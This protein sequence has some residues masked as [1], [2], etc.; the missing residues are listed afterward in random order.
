MARKEIFLEDAILDDFSQG[1]EAVE[2]PVSFSVFK[3]VGLIIFAVI[4]LFALRFIYIGFGSDFYKIRALANA[5]Q[6]IILTAPRGAI[7]D[8][9][10][11]SLVANNPSFDA[12]LSLSQLLKRR[13]ELD[14]LLEK[15]NIIVP[16]D[17]QTV[18]DSILSA[19][20]ERQ[21]HITLLKNIS[22]EQSLAIKNLNFDFLLVEN[23]FSR[24]YI[25]GEV[26]S[27]VLGY[28]GLV[29]RNDLK[30]DESFD[31]N[32]E[33]GKSGL[34][35]YYDK[36][37]RGK[38]GSAVFFKDAL[39]NT[40]EEKKF[41]D[42]VSG[43]SL[44]T[45]L[46][47]DLQRFFYTELKN[48]LNFLG[49]KS[50]AGLIMDPSN[51][52]ILSMVSL[53]S[54]DNN[55]LSSSLFSDSL[56]PTFN[57][58]ISGIYSP[59]STIKP[60]VAFGALEEKVVDPLYSIFSAGYIEIPNPY[61]P[62]KPSRFVDW[63]AHGWVNLY[64]ALAR[65]SNV[66]FYEVGGGFSSKG[67]SASGGENLKGLGVYRLIDYWKKFLLDKKTG[68]DIVGESV[69]ILPD[70]EKKEERTGQIWRIGD[71]YN[72]SI[73]Q[74]DLMISPLALL[75][76]VSAINSKGKFFNP[77]LVKEIKNNSGGTVFVRNSSYDL[78]EFSDANNFSEVEKGMIDGVEKEYGTSHI[79]NSIPLKIAAKTGSAQVENNAKVN[80]FFVGY[81]LLPTNVDGTQT[82]IAP[83]QIAVLVLIEDAKEGSLNA[84]PVAKKV[85]EWYYENRLK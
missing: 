59:G 6:E 7:Y 15:I 76:Y 29:S 35:A 41:S 67:G 37:L 32:D 58:I 8:R 62:D 55:D 16:F 70:P 18:R 23:N 83:K 50:G 3:I 60:L 74:G 68:I 78:M 53:P 10:G 85:F 63:K 73:G 48:Q 13:D 46:D 22:L 4:L 19:N 79:L 51:G 84:V 30:T 54:F 81:N 44:T 56:R 52:E 75:R 12:V 45:T 34:E 47:A 39:G 33:I 80:A 69:G 31:L 71:T 26:F 61:F 9:Y 82:N 28:V 27:H 21:S 43:S 77:Y 42:P 66:Y 38:K 14:D 11:T 40:I 17:K 5:G 64:S 57:R 65:S 36:Y 20:L 24:R 25:D 49:R 1:L 2:K 72:V